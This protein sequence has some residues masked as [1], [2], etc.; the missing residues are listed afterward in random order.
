MIG[1]IYY[2][3]LR[4]HLK[5]MDIILFSGTG[6]FSR[7]V[8]LFTFSKYSHVGLVMWDH[9]GRCLVV[10]SAPWTGLKDYLTK[11]KVNGV[12]AVYLSERVKA[13][14]GKVYWRRLMGER[15]ERTSEKFRQVVGVMSGTP[16]ERSWKELLGAAWRTLKNKKNLTSVFCSEFVAHLF[17]AMGVLDPSEEANEYT[18]ED[19]SEQADSLLPLTLGYGLGQT[20][21]VVYPKEA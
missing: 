9:D 3:D 17:I 7:I 8:R 11:N 18:P 15:P 10:E 19:F 12:Q 2:D 21:E 13:Y 20:L 5:E 16:Y 1:R 6:F 14:K 4:P